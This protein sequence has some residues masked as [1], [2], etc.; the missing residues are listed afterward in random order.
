[1]LGSVPT[2]VTAQRLAPVAVGL[3][4]IGAA[5]MTVAPA[6]KMPLVIG[7]VISLGLVQEAPVP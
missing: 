5:G 4:A 3:S 2:V 6:V 7:P 1:M